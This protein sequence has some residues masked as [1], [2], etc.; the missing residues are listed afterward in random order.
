[1]DLCYLLSE[2]FSNV[3]CIISLMTRFEMCHLRKLVNNYKYR[4]PNIDLGKPK[5][6]SIEMSTHG[7][8]V[9]GRC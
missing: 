7:L 9:M 6:K 3:G 8:L 2:Q 1:M 5:T 4:I